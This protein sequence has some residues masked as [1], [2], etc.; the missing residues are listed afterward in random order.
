M[1]T[2]ELIKNRHSALNFKEGIPFTEN[3]IKEVFEIVKNIPSVWN[4]QPTEFLIVT[5]PDLKELVYNLNCQQYKIKS[6]SA[7][8]ITMVNRNAFTVEHAEKIYTPMLQLKMMDEA[9]YNKSIA[10]VRELINRSNID[11]ELIMNAGIASSFLMMTLEAKGWNSCQMHINNVDKI[12][13]I[14]KI[15]VHMRPV[16]LMAIGKSVDAKRP[17]GYRK[18]VAEFVHINNM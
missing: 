1:P 16:S 17:R 7:V 12:K 4:L 3:D 10:Q 13:R 9:T 15:P 5:D 6:A 18:P 2:I 14:F 11:E 8:V